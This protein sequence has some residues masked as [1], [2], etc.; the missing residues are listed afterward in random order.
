MTRNNIKE[1]AKVIKIIYVSVALLAV[2]A[3][4]IAAS[5]YFS[6]SRSRTLLRQSE[7]DIRAY[8]LELTPIGISMQEAHSVIG[9]HFRVDEWGHGHGAG[10]AF[11]DYENGIVRRFDSRIHAYHPPQ[12]GVKAIGLELGSYRRSGRLL[13][14][15]FVF[16]HWGFDENFELIDVYISKS[17]PAM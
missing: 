5:A 13:A 3:F 16:A 8:I 10:R 11:I 17:R 7:E 15:T 1:D 9:Q 4:A 12:I 2:I 14:G 6:A